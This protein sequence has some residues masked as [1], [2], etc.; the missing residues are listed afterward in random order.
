MYLDGVKKKNGIVPAK[1][2][3]FM[4]KGNRE[5]IVLTFEDGRKKICT[6]E[7]PIFTSNN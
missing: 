4:H 2:C 3:G 6:P 7:H 1:Q 5:F